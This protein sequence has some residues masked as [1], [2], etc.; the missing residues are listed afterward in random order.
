MAKH[1]KHTTHT[2]HTPKGKAL[3]AEEPE[4]TEAMKL[5]DANT[6][7]ERL[8]ELLSEV[9]QRRGGDGKDAGV[10]GRLPI[11]RIRDFDYP[12]LVRAVARLPVIYKEDGLDNAITYAQTTLPSLLDALNLVPPRTAD[13]VRAQHRVKAMLTEGQV[14]LMLRSDRVGARSRREFLTAA[15]TYFYTPAVRAIFAHGTETPPGLLP[16]S[17]SGGG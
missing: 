1:T 4:V 14:E 7:I 12:A 3:K 15:E 5:D 11:S 16:V 8:R 9:E 13:L 2:T 10:V 17:P 6:E